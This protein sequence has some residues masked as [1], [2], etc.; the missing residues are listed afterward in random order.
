VGSLV[1]YDTIG[2]LRRIPLVMGEDIEAGG[3]FRR[4]WDSIRLFFQGLR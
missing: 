4:L 2:E 3:F 1:F